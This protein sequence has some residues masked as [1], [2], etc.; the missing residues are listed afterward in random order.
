MLSVLTFRTPDEAVEKANNTPY[1]LSAGVWTE[2]GSRILWMAAA[3]AGR[4]D[5]GEHVQPLRPGVA[6]RRL[7]GV[8]L[9]PR[10]R[11]A[12]ARAV[13]GV[14]RSG[15]NPWLSVAAACR[16]RRPTSSTSAAPSRARSRAAR[17]RPRGKTS[18]GHR[19]RTSA[20][21]YA[22]RAG[23]AAEVGGH[24]R[25]QPGPSAVSSR[26]DARRRA[27]REF[28]R[29]DRATRPRVRRRSIGSSGTRAGPTSSAQVL[30]SANPGRG[31][32]FQLHSAGADRRRRRA[33]PRRAAAA[34]TG[35]GSRRC[36]SVATPPSWSRPKS[37]RSR[38][39]SSPRCSRRLT[40]PAVS[41]TS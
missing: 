16:S 19:G 3:A 38:R 17:M 34:R 30:G 21:R 41:S 39:S 14:R 29:A 18:R 26:R 1:G 25:V 35:L 6:V 12:R 32:V 2:K 20:T 24:D 15:V 27:T 22:D 5:L 37:G 31:T 28:A 23:R 9:R 13:S 36:W 33:G 4:R 8:G 40:S 7:Q 10:G 11:A